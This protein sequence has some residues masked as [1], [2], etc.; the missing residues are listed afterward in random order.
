VKK[1]FRQDEHRI[2]I[3]SIGREKMNVQIARKLR[4]CPM[5]DIERMLLNE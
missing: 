3:D 5:P 1:I 2:P 4:L